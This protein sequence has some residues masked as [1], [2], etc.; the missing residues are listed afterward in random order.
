MGRF[1]VGAGGVITAGIGR[2]AGYGLA[3][4]VWGA[5]YHAGGKSVP[6]GEALIASF[7]F[8]ILV[9][10]FKVLK[11]SS[12]ESFHLNLAHRILAVKRHSP[13][14]GGQVRETAGDRD[15]CLMSQRPG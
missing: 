11:V 8:L 5:V 15:S 13:A 14:L 1:D 3:K 9:S 7:T 12:F 2:F 6:A 4:V 10:L